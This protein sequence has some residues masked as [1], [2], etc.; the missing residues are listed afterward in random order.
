[1]REALREERER[2]FWDRFLKLFMIKVLSPLRIVGMWSGRRGH[3]G[4]T[5][6]EVG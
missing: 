6:V 4:V 2:L 3:P 1:M 5:R